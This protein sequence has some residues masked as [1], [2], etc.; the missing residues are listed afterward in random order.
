M[1]VKDAMIE[2]LVRLGGVDALTRWAR[3]NRTEFYK[4][5]ARLIPYEIRAEVSGP[6]GGDIPH[7][8]EHTGTVKLSVCDRID[9]LAEAFER[10]AERG[11]AAATTDPRP[12]E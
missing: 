5:A 9:Q 2:T 3:R 8:H 1:V 6:G 4:L 12:Q 10:A 7:T 11:E